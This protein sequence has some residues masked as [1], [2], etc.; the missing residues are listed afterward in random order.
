MPGGGPNLVVDEGMDVHGRLDASILRRASVKGK[1]RVVE[2]EG[3]RN[4]VR[5]SLKTRSEE[6]EGG[7]DIAWPRTLSL[8]LV[9]AGL[10][11]LPA[12]RRLTR[13]VLEKEG[14]EVADVERRGRPLKG[15]RGRGKKGGPPPMAAVGATSAASRV[16]SVSALE[17]PPWE[18]YLGGRAGYAA[19]PPYPGQQHRQ[20]GPRAAYEPTLLSLLTC[21]YALPY[22]LSC[23]AHGFAALRRGPS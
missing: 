15:E 5:D 1:A 20:R 23:C 10:A 18:D 9:L 8:P 2:V 6:E 3:G 16:R 11:T 13:S 19:R 7:G 22:A 4:G 21:T 14:E 12:G 17:R